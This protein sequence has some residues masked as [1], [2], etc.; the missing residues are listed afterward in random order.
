MKNLPFSRQENRRQVDAISYRNAAQ[1]IQGLQPSDI[2]QVVSNVYFCTHPMTGSGRE[3][4]AKLSENFENL[5]GR[6]RVQRCADGVREQ[7]IQLGR[8]WKTHSFLFE[9]EKWDISSAQKWLEDRKVSSEIIES[10]SKEDYFL[11]ESIYDL[12]ESELGEDFWEEFRRRIWEAKRNPMS[13]EDANRELPQIVDFVQ[14]TL[15]RPSNEDYKKALNIFME[16]MGMNEAVDPLAIIEAFRVAFTAAYN[17]FQGSMIDTLK[18]GAATNLVILTIAIMIIGGL[19]PELSWKGFRWMEKKIFSWVIKKLSIKPLVASQVNLEMPQRE[20]IASLTLHPGRIYFIAEPVFV[21]VL[22]LFYNSY[23]SALLAGE[24]F[25]FITFAELR[26]PGGDNRKFML[27]NPK[28]GAYK[29]K[30][31]L[32]PLIN[33]KLLHAGDTGQLVLDQVVLKSKKND[34]NV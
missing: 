28:I 5:H 20:K 31:C 3:F 32:I 27:I 29:D 25:S 10:P 4:I 18:Y 8:I 6:V 12:D 7:S 30:N 9:K 16:E 24:R 17:S 19:L 21:I 33:L 23:N 11:D 15:P 2:L 26:F 14:S 34:K 22:G 13:V 1:N